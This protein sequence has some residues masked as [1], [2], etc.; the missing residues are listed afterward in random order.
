[1]DS[2]AV[3]LDGNNLSKL[4]PELFLGRNKVTALYLNSSKITGL[5]KRTF[6]GLSG[7]KELYLDHNELVSLGKGEFDELTELEVLYLDNNHLQLISVTSLSSLSMLRM[8]SLHSNMLVTLQLEIASLA[9]LE[10][11]TIDANRWQCVT[12]C[13]WLHT[14]QKLDRVAAHQITCKDGDQAP[15]N[16]RSVMASC[17]DADALPVSSHSSSSPL[18]A[19]IISVAVV[20]LLVLIIIGFLFIIRHSIT[21]WV[22]STPKTEEP[23]AYAVHKTREYTAYLH[24]CLADE[25]YVRQQIAPALSRRAD[26][27]RL[28]LHHADLTTKT[29]V[30]QAIARA[31]SQSQ[32]L[33]ILASQAY[34]HSSIPSYELQMIL[35]CIKAAVMVRYPVMVLVRAGDVAG[36]RRQFTE[37]VGRT[38]CEGWTFCDMSDRD[39]WGQIDRWLDSQ[40]DRDARH[41]IQPDILQHSDMSGMEAV[42]AEVE[43]LKSDQEPFIEHRAIHSGDETRI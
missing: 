6:V 33:L 5:S 42:Y 3:Y 24:Y 27:T 7:L 12:A 39:A 38:A 28:C 11:V 35:A 36:M 2:T 4:G 34:F 25:E 19:I 23:A 18:V 9:E 13:Q 41:N 16:M 17:T 14:W 10:S 29:S 30:G 21:A 20:I 40:T 22:Y 1:M 43:D 31:V 15:Q 8:L 26:R 37:I 32:C